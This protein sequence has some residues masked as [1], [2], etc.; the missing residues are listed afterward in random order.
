MRQAEESSEKRAAKRE[1]RLGNIYVR[2]WSPGNRN[3]MRSR[4]FQIKRKKI[5]G[6]QARVAKRADRRFLVAASVVENDSVWRRLVSIIDPASPGV[7]QRDETT[8][9]NHAPVI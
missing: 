1:W 3:L 4:G 9:V 7:N 6:Q 5:A 2:P 8:V